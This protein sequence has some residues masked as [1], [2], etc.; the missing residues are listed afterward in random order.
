MRFRRDYLRLLCEHVALTTL[1]LRTF[2]E[3]LVRN[4]PEI[5]EQVRGGPGRG[6][7][8]GRG[9]GGGK[10]EEEGRRKAL[11]LISP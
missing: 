11:S 4:Q 5:S 7:G 3:K 6:G 9:K 10:G 2:S 1:S 8:E